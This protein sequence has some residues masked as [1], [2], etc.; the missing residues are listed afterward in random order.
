M[1]AFRQ[2]K[3]LIHTEISKTKS[4]TIE[5]G[6]TNAHQAI[7]YNAYYYC[8]SFWAGGICSFSPS[9][10]GRWV[11]LIERK[12]E[13]IRER[14]S[15]IHPYG[16]TSPTEFYAVVSEYFFERPKLLERKHPELYAMLEEIFDHDLAERAL[17]RSRMEI[18][19]NSPCPCG[20]GKK[21]KRC[22]LKLE[23]V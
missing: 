7:L 5:K 13:E 10:R 17:D 16:G 12:L 15:D 9:P 1:E 2:L 14:K 11:D 4:S 19:R 21:Y 18:G 20:S 6:K 8:S 3:H 23:Y 22:C